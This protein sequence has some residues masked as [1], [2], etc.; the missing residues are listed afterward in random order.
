VANAERQHECQQED[1]PDDDPV[2][3]LDPREVESLLEALGSARQVAGGLPGE[4]AQSWKRSFAFGLKPEGF[5]VPYEPVAELGRLSRL[6]D[7][8]MQSLAGDLEGS[9]VSALLVDAD[10]HIL[11]RHVTDRALNERLDQIS[12]APGFT[13][14]ENAIGTNAIG[15]AVARRDP[16]VVLG[17]EHFA[18]SLTDMACAASPIIDETTGRL[19]GLVDLTS[20][21]EDVNDLMLPLAKQASRAI[22]ER[23]E[24][25]SPV[26][27][28]EILGQ[29]LG[30]RRR[31]K[32]PFVVVSGTT[33][34]GNAAASYLLNSADEASLREH[35]LEVLS[36]R[37]ET[38]LSE[39][40][41]AEGQRLWIDSARLDH[42]TQP[43]TALLRIVPP[44][45][46]GDP[47]EA[48]TDNGDG[49]H[50]WESLTDTEKSVATLVASGLT[51]REA[52][53]RL[54]VSP[55][56]VDFHLRSIFRKLEVR[57]RV[58][59]ARLVA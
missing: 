19:I 33:I 50:G 40:V 32:G 51:N 31:I 15:T 3:N 23:L 1:H 35:G 46:D 18:D 10:G 42:P 38:G 43:P 44:P 21:A 48:E 49:P 27:K 36:H 29:F 45:A 14:S 9:K 24:A 52:A 55:Y 20:F 16:S 56:T 26:A 6:A 2:P 57:S 8:I 17:A 5:E 7:P 53:A 59:L 37:R 47:A 39:I 41:L 54:L 4:V 28:R 34:L 58:E 11:E 30:L 22:E 13:Y 12:L 25:D